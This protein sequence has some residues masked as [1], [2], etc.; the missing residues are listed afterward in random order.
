MRWD[1]PIQLPM[2]TT[3]DLFEDPHPSTWAAQIVFGGPIMSTPYTRGV[4]N[5]NR[6]KLDDMMSYPYARSTRRAPTKEEL[7]GSMV[8]SFV[9]PTPQ[10]PQPAPKPVPDPVI[11]HHR[12]TDS[13]MFNMSFLV[14][15]TLIMFPE[16]RLDSHYGKEGKVEAIN[17]SLGVYIVRAN[18]HPS[19][20]FLTRDEVG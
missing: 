7:T 15:D 1:R 12:T 20:I 18:V 2:G 6:T 3:F 4:R 16:N 5:I 17:C 11:H 19:L 13:Y 14:G 10:P 8:S 9:E